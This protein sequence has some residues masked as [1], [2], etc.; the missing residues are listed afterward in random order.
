MIL[1][2]S[3]SLLW[4]QFL[5]YVGARPLSNFL[6]VSR[7]LFHFPGYIP[8][9]LCGSSVY[10][11]HQSLTAYAIVQLSPGST[12][13]STVILQYI[14]CRSRWCEELQRILLATSDN[15]R[16]QR[17]DG[18]LVSSDRSLTW[19][20]FERTRVG[21]QLGIFSR[22]NGRRTPAQRIA[23]DGIDVLVEM[24]GSLLDESV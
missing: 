13:R 22:Q 17:T 20:F 8:A 4:R 7:S 18:S 5:Q 2:P 14:F 12:G 11:C 10:Y 3:S 9:P 6:S 15:V 21:S 16:C 19:A 24:T 1:A 23:H